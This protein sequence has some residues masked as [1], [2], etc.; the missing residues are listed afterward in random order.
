MNKKVVIIYR[1]IPNYRKAF[2]EKLRPY[3]MNQGIDLILVYGQPGKFDKVKKDSTEIN[4]GK[5]IN[6]KIFYILGKE[7]YWQPAFKYVKIADLVIVE[8]AS[9]LLINYLLLFLSILGLKKIAFWGHGKN[10]QQENANKFGEW[11][12][13]IISTR[14]DWWFAYNDISAQ[15][16]RDLG[17]PEKRITSVQNTIDVEVLKNEKNSWSK[18]NIE[19]FKYSENIGGSHIGLYIGGM[20]YEKRLSFLLE[21]CK[22]IKEKIIDFEMIFIGSGKD[23]GIVQDFSEENAW[24]HFLGPKFGKETVPYFLISNLFLMPGSVGLAIIDCF[25][26]DVPLITIDDN[27]HGPEISYME[28]EFNGLLLSKTNN[29][30]KYA[31]SVIDLFVNREKIEKLKNGCRKSETKYSIEKMV[32]NFAEGIMKAILKN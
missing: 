11:V 5:K 23:A 18:K 24:I 1:Y 12:K 25:V 28:N 17:F 31:D 10:F 2:Y 6:N 16:I 30:Q 15:I 32:E 27:N 3:L 21:T 22:L 19:K 29:P 8:Q 4:W 14:V 20:Y 7:I 9:K 13:K 26:M